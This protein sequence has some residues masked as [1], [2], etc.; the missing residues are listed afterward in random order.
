MRI[1][2][3]H[4]HT[5]IGVSMST[6]SRSWGGR[7]RI[8]GGGGGCS[9]CTMVRVRWLSLRFQDTVHLLVQD[10]QAFLNVRLRDPVREPGSDQCRAHQFFQFHATV[11]NGRQ[12]IKEGEEL[13]VNR[14]RGPD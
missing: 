13:A 2:N 6:T 5:R 7:G 11:L 8:G 12:A 3:I 4:R 9:T 14:G 1:W 10:R